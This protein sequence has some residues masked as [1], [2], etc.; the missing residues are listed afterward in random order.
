MSP[1]L[2]TLIA[3]FGM[4]FARSFVASFA[5]RSASFAFSSLRL[6]ALGLGVIAL[7]IWT[8]GC[9]SSSR[10][11]SSPESREAVLL[12]TSLPDRA[13][14]DWAIDAKFS[15][16][17]QGRLFGEGRY[18]GLGNE[19]LSLCQRL[20]DTRISVQLA[21]EIG[22][23]VKSELISMTEGLDERVDPAVI[24]N[25]MTE[26]RA[27]LKG[28]RIT[29]RYFERSLVNGTE[30]ISCFSRGSMSLKEFERAKVGLRHSLLDR[31]PELR[32]LI[33]ERQ[34]KFLKSESEE[35]TTSA[36]LPAK[37][38]SESASGTDPNTSEALN[39]NEEKR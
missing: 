8:T 5:R 7:V 29:D 9:A 14:A 22:T 26:A 21:E 12:E 36:R 4:L 32:R 30:R 17:A 10:N 18:D 39:A 28:L 1:I 11:T 13:R 38:K 37:L 33:Q 3:T 31:S 34:Q 2:S 15:E 35:T 6:L 27:E 20:A 24:E 16:E 23:Q 19:R 25:I